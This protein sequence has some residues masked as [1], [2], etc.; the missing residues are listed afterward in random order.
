[1][2]A[3]KRGSGVAASVRSMG[4]AGAAA[5]AACPSDE[6]AAPGEP[7]VWGEWAAAGGA[8]APGERAAAGEAA[9]PGEA[10]VWGERAASGEAAAPGE[11]ASLGE[12]GAEAGMGTPLSGYS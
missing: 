12:W 8:A 10:A 6:A 7:A 1:M 9:A 2:A 5:W 11:A 4:P 3:A